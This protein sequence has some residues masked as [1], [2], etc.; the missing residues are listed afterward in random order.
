MARYAYDPYGRTTAITST[1]P[2]DFQYAGMYA[3]SFS[4][5]NLTFHNTYDPTV[6]RWK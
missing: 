3:H 6:G 4:G 2:S 5:L 1:V